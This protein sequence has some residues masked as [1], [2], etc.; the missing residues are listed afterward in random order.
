MS[1][2][3]F[4][5]SSRDHV[6]RADIHREGQWWECEAG[7]PVYSG[8]SRLWTA[9]YWMEHAVFRQ[10]EWGQSGMCRCSPKTDKMPFYL[11]IAYET[12][13][14][15]L[16]YSSQALFLPIGLQL[17]RSLATWSSVWLQNCFILFFRIKGFKSPLFV[18][19]VR[20]CTNL[21]C[22]G[23]VSVD[24]CVVQVM[25]YK[26]CSMLGVNFLGVLHC[27]IGSIQFA[28]QM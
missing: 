3:R 4:G 8:P 15:Y 6:Y 28:R 21:L 11:K 14:S 26:T 18:Q 10:P 27:N 22:N 12:F 19:C 2:S 17:V 5:L 1:L 20:F 24:W 7:L 23:G 25:K 13:D 16:F 9:G